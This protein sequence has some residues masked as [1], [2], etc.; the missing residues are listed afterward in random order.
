[1]VKNTYDADVSFRVFVSD[2]A[3]DPVPVWS[4]EV[5][6][7]TEGGNSILLSTDILNLE[8]AK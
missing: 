6:R 2:R 4:T 8:V 3:E 1:M 7:G 5:S